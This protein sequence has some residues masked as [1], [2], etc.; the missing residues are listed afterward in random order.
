MARRKK[1]EE[2]TVIAETETNM[3][4]VA[5]V[6][7]SENITEAV[8]DSDVP[9]QSEA[10]NRPTET[11]NKNPAMNEAEQEE[12]AVTDTIATAVQNQDMQAIIEILKEI[13]QDNIKEVKYAKRQ[14]RFAII[15]SV[16]AMAVCFL[17]AA[18]LIYIVPQ[19][20][21]LI[22]QANYIMAET[23][24]LMVEADVVMKNMETVTDELAQADLTGM[25][26]NVNTLV[27]SSEAQLE[28]AM[29]KI[30]SMDI[31]SLNKAIR[32]LGTIVNPLA[33]LFGGKR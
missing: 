8:N 19:V 6:D 5:N 21:L 27:V 14:S 11:V 22:D 1:M 3:E 4:A 31:D 32:D 20:T 29:S 15:T 33:R 10:E 25:L 30:D 12:E 24:E 26:D 2:T 28:E 18:A 13:K 17:L 9:S 23:N 16:A 7:T